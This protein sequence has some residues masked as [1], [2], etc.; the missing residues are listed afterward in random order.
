MLLTITC[1]A[2]NADDL[3]YLLHKN[4]ANVFESALAFGK[5]T[6]CWPECRADRCTAALLL[7]V[8]PVGLVRNRRRTHTLEQYVNDRPYVASSLLSV[9]LVEA[10]STAMNGR[11][12]ERPERV[13][14]KMP[15]EVHIDVLH[16]ANAAEL[17]PRL[18]EPLGYTVQ[19]ERLPLDP[20][21]PT[22]GESS[23][24]RLTLL[25]AQTV[26]DLLSHLYVL[27]PVLDNSKHYFVGEDE[28]EKLLKK[29][30][31]WLPAHPEYALIARRYLNYRQARVREAVERIEA[32]QEDTTVDQDEQDA[33]AGVQEEAAEAP[34]RL[35]EDRLQTA[36]EQV[37]S[38]SPPAERA[39]DL[40]CG[41]GRLV[42]MLLEERGLREIVG[43]DV[44]SFALDRASQRL[45]L[46]TLPPRQRDRVR[47]L[48]GSIVYRDDR[49]AGFDVALLIE[50]IEHLDP[51]RLTA[52]EGV[53]FGHARPRRVV[54]T[55]P[56][57]EYNRKWPTLPAGKFRHNDH[58]FEWTREEFHDWSTRVGQ[59]KGYTVTWQGIGP[60]D[61]E[62]GA[63]TQMA[64][65]D[66]SAV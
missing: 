48:H 12:R 55:T 57:A 43:I 19:L 13:T 37:R 64:I 61:S 62:L 65:F 18:F 50:V 7:D 51:P 22:W 52:M 5:V 30:E 10:F 49:F 60:E 1:T 38:L 4:P 41:E 36:V 2:P 27:I 59:E 20:R 8:D 28:V 45:H 63:P 66:R 53:V 14:E 21:F 23:V 40:G 39:L 29:G 33:E 16:V 31:R 24:V 17:I 35:H 34:L 42:K 6:V 46:D 44:S 15:F 11:S 25:G 9:A 32:L 26:Q 54:I 47:L 56:N 58:R 3:G